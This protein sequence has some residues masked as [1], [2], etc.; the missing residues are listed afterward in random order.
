MIRIISVIIAI[1]L[2]AAVGVGAPFALVWA[3]NTVFPALA[4]P[5]TWTV[6]MA[7]SLIWGY[8]AAAVR[9]GQRPPPE[10]HVKNTVYARGSVADSILRSARAGRPL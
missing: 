9:L 5:Y 2:I 3:L 8:L 10:Y 4:I 1:I 6:W 7:V